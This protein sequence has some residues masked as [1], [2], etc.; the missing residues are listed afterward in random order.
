MGVNLI[1]VTGIKFSYN[2]SEWVLKDISLS[3]GKGEILSIIG[4]NGSGKSTLLKLLAGIERPQAGSIAIKNKPIG[5]M[6][7]R[8][9]AKILG[10]LPQNVTSEFDYTAEEI[11]ALGRFPHLKGIGFLDSR[12]IQVV[13][14]SLEAADLLS[15]RNRP[16]S[17]ISG[18]ERQRVFLASV[19]AQEP[20]MLL[21]D[22]PTASL[23]IHH[24]ARFYSLL[25]GLAK[26][27][28]GIM[29]VTHDINLATVF[30]GRLLVLKEGC[31]FADGTPQEVVKKEVLHSVYGDSLCI[32]KHPR[33]G[34]PMVFPGNE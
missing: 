26:T 25:R 23:D 16:L 5:R 28:L 2:D 34:L 3:L 10:Y 6:A 30:T 8:Q 21:L 9:L 13:N 17:K 14:R 31:I 4:P 24:Q 29:V 7:R 22:E 33:G 20:E 15:L 11:V 12:D 19:L 18:G 27:G 32:G 1:T